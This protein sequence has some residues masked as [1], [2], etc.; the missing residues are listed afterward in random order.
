MTPVVHIVMA[1]SAVDDI[2]L[3]VV[4]VH[5]IVVAG[6]SEDDVLAI[7]GIEC[8]CSASRSDRVSAIHSVDL[9]PARPRV[10]R[11]GTKTAE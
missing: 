10:D 1:W 4:P 7:V 2:A 8:V 3:T 11:D 5:D 6:A 9:V